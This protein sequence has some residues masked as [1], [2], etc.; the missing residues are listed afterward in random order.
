[1]PPLP[2]LNEL[3]DNIDGIDGLETSLDRLLAAE[4][5]ASY[6]NWLSD[7]L[8][9]CLVEEVRAEGYSWADIGEQLGISR[10]GAQQRYAPRQESVT[11]QDL[12]HIG[13]LK[14]LTVRARESLDGAEAYAVRSGAAAVTPQHLLLAL[15]DDEDSLATR[16]LHSCEFS[17]A[18]IRRELEE[19]PASDRPAPSRPPTVSGALRKCF[20]A[21]FAQAMSLGHNY[22]GTEHLLLGITHERRNPAAQALASAGVTPQSARDAVV[23]AI[24]DYLQSR[25]N[26]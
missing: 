26:S 4:G 6:L 14:R 8:V 13:A 16:A 21:S 5:V 3:F 22:V 10:Q 15:L 12:F 11:L 23:S 25:Q 18:A 1:M 20:D 19:E 24:S 9:G 17:L 7:R 2:D